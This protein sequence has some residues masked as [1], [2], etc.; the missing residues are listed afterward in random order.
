MPMCRER[1]PPLAQ[2]APCGIRACWLN[3]DGA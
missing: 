1:V 2:I 3:H